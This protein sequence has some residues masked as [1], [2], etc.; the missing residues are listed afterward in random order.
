METVKQIWENI[1]QETLIDKIKI[2]I[3]ICYFFLIRTFFSYDKV[4]K[5]YYK[6][7]LYSCTMKKKK[8]H[9]FFQLNSFLEIYEDYSFLDTIFKDTSQVFIDIGANIGRISSLAST[10][11]T[12]QKIFALDANPMCTNFMKHFIP[13]TIREK[14][15]ILDYGIGDYTKTTTM[16]ITSDVMSP[17][18]TLCKEKSALGDAK[19]TM[20]IKVKIL[21]FKDFFLESKLYIYI[22]YLLKI[23]VE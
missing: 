14:I 15:E 23:D 3:N 21:S 19:Q 22:T 6:K 11:G 7:V 16:L 4:A 17:C 13:H 18:G 8:I 20:E 10:Y 12:F 2:I 5:F 1:K 9:Y